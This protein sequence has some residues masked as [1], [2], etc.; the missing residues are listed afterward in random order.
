MRTPELSDPPPPSGLA[1]LR[2]RFGWGLVVLGVAVN[3]L[4]VGLLA[5]DGGVASTR[6]RLA[7]VGVEVA[8]VLAGVGLLRRWD[9]ALAGRGTMMRGVVACAVLLLSASASEALIRLVMGPLDRWAPAPT[10][11]GEVE[12]RPSEN[13][14]SDPRIGW[15][16][17]EHAEFRWRID[18]VESSY[19]AT[20]EGFRSAYSVGE[21]PDGEVLVTVVGDSFA[22]GTGV[23]ADETFAALLDRRLE[24]VAVHNLALPGMGIDQMWMVMRHHALPLKPRLVMIAFIDQDWDRSLTAFRTVEG[25]SKPTF[26][27]EGA[28]LRPAT[29]ADAP[30]AAWRWLERRSTLI[31][32]GRAVDRAAGYGAGVGSWWATNAAILEAMSEEARVAGARILFV[33]LPLRRAPGFPALE[34]F[35]NGL[36]VPFLDLNGALPKGLHFETDDHINAAGHAYVAAAVGP[37]VGRLVRN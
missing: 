20:S 12:S 34:E 23:D 28:R 37:E 9:R 6:V 32:L 18:G 31:A 22:F 2:R 14:V 1:F 11:V 13:F 24:G 10:Y 16:M 17:R 3:P 4:T 33:R 8:L 25:M 19:R 5:R 26:V 30:S 15:R 29:P 27:L 35:M 36:G 21:I 7:I